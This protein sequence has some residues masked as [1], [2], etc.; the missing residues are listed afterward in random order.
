MAINDAPREWYLPVNETT[1]TGDK[2]PTGF[3]ASADPTIGRV[4]RVHRMN[5]GSVELWRLRAFAALVVPLLKRLAKLG[6]AK[7]AIDSR[8]ALAV[9]DAGDGK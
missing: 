6:F 3:S 1:D 9:L 5:E 8:E 4:D 2:A 7:S